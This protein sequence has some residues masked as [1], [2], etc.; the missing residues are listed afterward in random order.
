MSSPGTTSAVV[1]LV[2]TLAML[3]GGIGGF[4]LA[5]RLIAADYLSGSLNLLYLTTVGL[6]VGYLFSS[7]L[8][9]RAEA[10]WQGVLERLARI[11]PDS[12]LAA[13][14]GATVAL[15]I[16]VL[17]NVILEG[18]PGFSWYWSLFIAAALVVSTS[19]FFVANKSLFAR[20]AGVAGTVRGPPQTEPEARPKVIDTS[21]II[22]GRIVD[23]F[24]CHFLDG[25]LLVPRFVLGELQH[26]ADADDS[27]RRKRGRRGLEVLDRLIE[28]PAV[29]AQVTGEDYPEV[30][31]VDAKL[32]RLCQARGA[33]LITT[34]FNLNR[35][36][37]LQGVRVLNV[38]ELAGAIKTVLLP[39]E[40]L[41]LQIV[42]PGREP[43]QGLAYLEDGTM[44]VV[45]DAAHLLGSTVEVAVT[46]N[47]QTNMGRMVFARLRDAN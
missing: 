24:A 45:E 34:D 19:W 35:V 32:I 29:K 23:V 11:P 28:Q 12:V 13:G 25:P 17:L 10:L 16:T 46:S 5:D 20:E 41:S 18:V 26:I 8:A 21:A 31:E 4:S 39:G 3:G 30:R 43:G 38:N 14:V 27:L 42:K 40:M 9:L 7:R 22:D 15:I 47:L 44:V 1:L 2:R 36:A 6:L 33:D 37:A